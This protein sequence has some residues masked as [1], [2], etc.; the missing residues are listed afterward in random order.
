MFPAL[1]HL[2]ERILVF[3]DFVHLM[4]SITVACLL[5]GGHKAMVAH[6]TLSRRV[7]ELEEQQQRD[8][9]A[10]RLLDHLRDGAPP[11]PEPSRY[12]GS[13]PVDLDPGPDLRPRVVSVV[14]D[15]VGGTLTP[16]G[17]R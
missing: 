12:L 13:E 9:L 7:R 6:D 5:Y 4:Q 15:A 16:T 8:Q 11:P 14:N 10:L 3:T 1:V 2:L 17:F